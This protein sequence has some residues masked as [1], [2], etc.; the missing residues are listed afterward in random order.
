MIDTKGLDHAALNTY[1]KLKVYRVMAS[2]L[3]ISI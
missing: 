3:L 1:D 2:L